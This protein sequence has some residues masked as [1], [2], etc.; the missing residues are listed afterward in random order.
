MG[1]SCT[2]TNKSPA[3]E[4]ILHEEVVTNLDVTGEQL[5]K[6]PTKSNLC[7]PAKKRVKGIV[8]KVCMAVYGKAVK[9]KLVMP[10]T[11][12]T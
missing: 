1:S 4:G 12:T 7:P 6:M 9:R 10:C 8:E 2:K 3:T 5:Y 11:G